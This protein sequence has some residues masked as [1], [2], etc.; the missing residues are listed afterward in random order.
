MRSENKRKSICMFPDNMLR[1]NSL[2]S[3]LE[4]LARKSSFV[5][6]I[7]YLWIEAVVVEGKKQKKT[8]KQY[9]A[10]DI[11]LNPVNCQLNKTVLSSNLKE[12]IRRTMPCLY[13]AMQNNRTYCT[14]TTLQSR[15][16]LLYMVEEQFCVCMSTR[17]SMHLS[18]SSM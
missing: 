3:T 13:L 14:M 16:F 1:Q 8:G 18:A 10:F 5:D 11:H 6:L 9:G 4:V 12:R 2:V 17:T 7:S 15:T